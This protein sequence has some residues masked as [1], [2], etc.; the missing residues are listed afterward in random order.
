MNSKRSPKWAKKHLCRPILP[1]FA[2]SRALAIA[3][4][5]LTLCTAATLAATIDVTAY[6]ATGDGATDD[7]AAIRNAVAALTENDTLLFPETD[8]HYKVRVDANFTINDKDGITILIRGRI[9][10]EGIPTNG[11]QVFRVTYSDYID[12][13]GEGG[14]A[15]IEGGD[16]CSVTMA[17]SDSPGGPFRS[18]GRPVVEPGAEDEWDC[19]CIHDP[20]PL[21]YKGRIWLYYK[22][23]PGQKRGGANIVRAQGVAVADSPAGPFEKSPLNPVSNSGH[24]TCLWPHREG[25]AAIFSL[26]GPEKNTVQYAPDGLN[27]DVKSLVVMP[28]IAPGPFVPD[29]FADN[30]DGRGITWGL[31]HINPDGGGPNNESILARFDCDLCHATDRGPLFKASNQRYDTPTYFQRVNALPEHLRKQAIEQVADPDTTV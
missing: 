14:D 19:A 6:G 13:V 4:V 9:R 30:G 28:P 26:D 5:V 20:F 29:A 11:N 23:S 16:T 17:E 10:A 3:V 7:T 21:I 18:L 22:G 31:C 24:E 27:F 25:I 15:I 12:F 2:F 8:Y 1:A